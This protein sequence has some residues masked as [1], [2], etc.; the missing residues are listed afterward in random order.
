MSEIPRGFSARRGRRDDR[1][2]ASRERGVASRREARRP[3]GRRRGELRSRAGVARE[4]CVAMSPRI[5]EKNK[6]CEERFRC[7]SQHI[8][9]DFPRFPEEASIQSSNNAGSVAG[10][11]PSDGNPMSSRKGNLPPRAAPATRRVPSSAPALAA[12]RGC[13]LPPPRRL[14]AWTRPTSSA[15][16]AWPRK[17]STRGS[18]S[19][20]DARWRRRT[21]RIAASVRHVR[22]R[23]A[24]PRVR[25]LTTSM[26]SR[27]RSERARASRR[28]SGG[29]SPRRC[30]RRSA[31]RCW[32]RW[33]PR[34]PP[35]PPPPRTDRR[36]PSHPPSPRRRWRRGA[37]GPPRRRRRRAVTPPATAA[38]TTDSRSARLGA[39]P[40][41]GASP[42]PRPRTTPQR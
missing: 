37:T 14:G 29:A 39:R 25:T 1:A 31:R 36:L 11:L 27:S 23:G 16:R 13:P 5:R 34:A 9:P 42:R 3:R 7:P 19:R 28:T 41:T 26:R 8:Q 35:R 32:P 15:R 2:G 30:S 10:R 18:S 24:R 21:G 33:D 6:A 12:R 40:T 20:A 17:T 22:R 38:T 4:R